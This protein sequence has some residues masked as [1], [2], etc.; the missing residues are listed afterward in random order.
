M[1]VFDVDYTL[2]DH[3]SSATNVAALQRPYL[4]E[5]MA[6]LYPY[7]DIFVWCVC[8]IH[9]GWYAPLPSCNFRSEQGAPSRSATSR[10]WV[11]LKLQQMGVLDHPDYRISCVMDAL[12]MVRWAPPEC[13]ALGMTD[14]TARAESKV[15]VPTEKYGLI[16]TKALAV[17]WGRFPQYGPHN[18]VLVDD[19]RRNYLSTPRN[20]IRVRPCRSLPMHRDTDVEL[21]LLRDYL[22]S[23]RD[24]HTLQ[25]DGHRRWRERVEGS[26][27]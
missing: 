19:L 10:R 6:A 27:I 14:G 16:N 18:T 21:R 1:V 5:M 8:G 7:Y 20:G 24:A 3:K 9:K 23:V 26:E 17:I 15:T 13:P 25:S 22:L 11:V 4:H 12:A 2:F